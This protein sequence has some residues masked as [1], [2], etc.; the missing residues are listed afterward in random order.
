MTVIVYVKVIYMM[1]FPSYCSARLPILNFNDI[2]NYMYALWLLSFKNW[3]VTCISC[4]FQSVSVGCTI[5]S[6]HVPVYCVNFLFVYRKYTG[7]IT[8]CIFVTLIKS[9]KSNISKPSYNNLKK[10]AEWHPT[11]QTTTLRKISWYK[12]YT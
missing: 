10:K 2:T 5:R 4:R 9:L 8:A 6:L 7:L 12:L 11:G 3:K 1:H